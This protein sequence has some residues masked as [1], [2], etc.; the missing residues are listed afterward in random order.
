MIIKTLQKIQI[1]SEKNK[2]KIVCTLLVI[3]PVGEIEFK[4][5]L[6]SCRTTCHK[7]VTT[8]RPLSL[9]LS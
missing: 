4:I 5:T 9:S 6:L 1:S 2:T 7:E 3:A 8:G